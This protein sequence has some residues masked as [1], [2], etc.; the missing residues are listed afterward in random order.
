MGDWVSSAALP[1]GL[2]TW[3][4]QID[5]QTYKCIKENWRF[6]VKKAKKDKIKKLQIEKLQETDNDI[7]STGGV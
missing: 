3:D 5:F 6:T 2:D 1:T 7:E 4:A